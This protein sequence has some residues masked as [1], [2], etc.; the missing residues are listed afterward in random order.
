MAQLV[1][2]IIELIVLGV[3][4]AV[5]AKN[6]K[7]HTKWNSLLEGL[8]PHKKLIGI[9][10]TIASVIIALGYIYDGHDWGGDFSEYIS[11]AIALVEGN[12]ALE[13]HHMQFVLENS[14][15]GM[16]P[17]VYPWGLPFILA[18][19]YKIFGFN[20]IV[21]R[22]VGVVCLGVFIW[23]VYKFLSKRFE[24]KDVMIMVLLFVTCKHYMES[25]TSILTDIP[26][27][28]LSM[29]AIYALYELIACEDKKQYYWSIIFA[30]TTAVAYI[31]RSSGL[32]LILTLACIHVVIILGRFVGWIGKCV[33]KT[34][35]KKVYVPA[36]IIPYIV[37]VIAK[38][39]IEA[40][41]PAAGNDYL[42]FIDGMPKT[43]P[44][45]NFLFYLRVLRDFFDVGNYLAIICG[46]I[47]LALIIIGMVV[48]FYQE[49]ISIV[50]ILGT[51][52]MLLIFPYVSGIRYIFGLYPMFLM[53]AFYG[54]QWILT[55]VIKKYQNLN[56]GMLMNIVRYCVVCVC[57]FM[58]V[59]SLRMI[60]KI[61]TQPHIDSAYTPEAMEAYEFIKANTGEEDVIM[62]FKPRVLWLNAG[63]Y[64]YNTYDDVNDLEKSDYV[65][66]FIKD[67][68]T[69]LRNHVNTHTD[70]Y[71]LL[72]D[73]VNFQI[74]KHN[75]IK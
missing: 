17:A 3:G 46:F 20:I 24:T 10:L 34:G 6:E 65:F 55:K 31:L 51:M 19:L 8:G 2:F 58:L 39:G 28:M 74:Y 53:F 4:I 52:A 32:V 41:L 18:V 35:L 13:V 15:P 70:E 16:C 47:L 38:F 63:R 73:N 7:I 50:F 42:K 30:V 59:F 12:V 43:Y 25:A 60:Y 21:F 23:Y 49:A 75:K 54:I 72:F 67:N 44:I 37:F 14:I 40:I 22:M 57:G 26:C 48:K 69:N 66:F 68:F 45:T 33:E 56:R 5:L 1:V 9:L 64:S 71:E 36:H 62:F 29:I 61:H 11:E 27:A